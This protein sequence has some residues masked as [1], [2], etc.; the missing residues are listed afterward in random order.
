VRNLFHGERVTAERLSPRTLHNLSAMASGVSP[1]SPASQAQGRAR[2]EASSFRQI[3]TRGNRAFF[4][5]DRSGGGLC[6][7]VADVDDPDVLGSIGCS[8][9]FPS[10]ERP[11]F[12]E[13][14]IGLGV[15]YDSKGGF[16]GL[17]RRLTVL[18]LEGFAADGVATV[19]L[20]MP[21]GRIE[22]VTPVEDNVYHRLD[23]LPTEPIAGIV[24]LDPEGHRICT[25]CIAR[26]GCEK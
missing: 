19:A 5:A 11:S 7:S 2:F 12:D 6:I 18:R 15:V 3:A 16:R 10:A 17:E 1:R 26:G 21:D 9:D 24:A 8:P 22:A 20:L 23:A 13:R 4:V 14:R 25:Q